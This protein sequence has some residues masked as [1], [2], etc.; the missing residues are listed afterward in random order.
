MMNYDPNTI[1][2]FCTQKV[3]LTLGTWNYRL[4]EEVEVHGNV[5]G[6]AVLESAVEALYEKLPENHDGVPQLILIDGENQLFCDDEEEHGKF[7]LE[8]YVLSAEIIGLEPEKHK[9]K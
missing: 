1:S 3:R 7:W 2:N 4:V 5:M 6:L 8:R 9:E